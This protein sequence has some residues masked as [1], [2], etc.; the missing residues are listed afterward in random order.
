MGGC[1]GSSGGFV[2]ESET[3]GFDGC[4][5]GSVE[6][7]CRR[8]D[9]GNGLGHGRRGTAWLYCSERSTRLIVVNLFVFKKKARLTGYSKDLSQR[10]NSQ[11]KLKKGTAQILALANESYMSFFAT[12]RHT[13]L[14]QDTEIA[15]DDYYKKKYLHL[16]NIHKSPNRMNEGSLATKNKKK[17]LR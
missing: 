13:Q 11:D 1:E 15:S 12:K 14:S 17:R 8:D 10:T 7:W 4:E 6:C 16:H 5:V 9:D 2:V 3:G